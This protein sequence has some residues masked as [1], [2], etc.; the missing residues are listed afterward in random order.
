M[1][2]RRNW[3]FWT[4]KIAARIL[5]WPI[6]IVKT[7]G[8]ENLPQ[9]SACI[10]LPKHQRW[11][12]IPLL[13]LAT[14]RP[15]CYVARFDLFENLYSNWFLRSLGGIPLN[16]QR[17]LESRASLKTIL[18]YL[19]RGEGIVVFPE[20]TYYKNTLGPG[21]SGM[22]KFVLSRMTL[23][24]IPVGIRYVPQGIRTVVRINFGNARFANPAVPIA[25]FLH[26]MMQEISVLS[27]LS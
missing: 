26:D 20:G 1:K 8:R 4:T 12:D 25:S 9:K 3:V 27:G 6:F 10:L 15:L 14:P 18:T 21:R 13:G 16:R 23:P 11:E 17:P 19:K 7:K 5:L 2:W 22:V 24:F